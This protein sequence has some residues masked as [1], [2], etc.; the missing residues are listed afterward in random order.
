MAKDYG[1]KRSSRRTSS[2]PQQLLL[3]V[4][5]FLLGYLT[6]SVADIN[7]LT[8]WMNEQVLAHHQVKKELVKAVAQEPVIPPKPKFEFYTLLA[9]EKGPN[10]T[11]A[12]ASSAGNHN[13][14]TAS[15][16]STSATAQ[17]TTTSAVATAGTVAKPPVKINNQSATVKVADAKPANPV[18]LR[19]NYLVQVAAFKARSDA[20]RMKGLLTLKGFDVS[21]VPVTTPTKGTWFRVVIGPYANRALAQ[22]AQV[23]LA[24]T[25][26]LKGMI[27]VG[28]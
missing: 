10:S 8:H 28:G 17:S 14:T 18:A 26:R 9:N 2:A 5:T 23:N 15:A 13:T 24:R 22:R 16:A 25:E 19:G 12:T 1:S 6:A 7:T 11:Q 4:V 27:T 3:V 20:E 21:V